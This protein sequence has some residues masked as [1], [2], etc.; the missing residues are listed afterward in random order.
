MICGTN[1]TCTLFTKEGIRLGNIGEET[2]SWV[3]CCDVDP[4]GKYVV[5]GS[6]DGTIAFYE[7]SFNVVHGLYKERYA[8]RDHMTD[9]IIHH[10]I[11]EKKVRIKCRDLV[12]KIAIYKNR[13]AVQ[14]PER[15]VI[16]E[17]VSTEDEDEMVYRSMEKI[18]RKMDCSLLV[19]CTKH[20]V[21]CD[22]KT[23]QSLFFSGTKDNEWLFD[24]AIRYIKVVGG[25][26]GKEQLILGLKNGQVWEIHLDNSFPLLRVSL[27]DGIKCLD[28]SE[29]KE[30][31]AVV[32]ENN[33][34]HIYDLDSSKLL[35]SEPEANCV[36]WNDKFEDM[37]VYSANN[38]M[39]I[40]VLDFPVYR[41]KL[42]G[43]VVGLTGSKLFYLK[44]G[45]S[46]ATMELPLGGPLSQYI[47]RKMF[48]EAYSL[49]CFG[50]ATLQLIYIKFTYNF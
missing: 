44:G 29:K 19:V 25:P 4:T 18:A 34:C 32:D 9:I 21:V 39:A 37:L 11:T 15:V 5:V 47:E 2:K 14:L 40:K 24:S 10:L 46:M 31:L 20:L 16:Y 49:A 12:K 33:H 22:E 38:F 45:T 3:W 7:L 8:F 30:K 43:F 50:T 42:Q 36:A 28:L 17:L 41:Q 23:V 27:R 13:L 26:P 48:K 35:S 6:N 1:K